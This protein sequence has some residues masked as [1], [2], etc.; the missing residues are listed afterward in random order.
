MS[1]N[2]SSSI[3]IDELEGWQFENLI[4]QLVVEMGFEAE[5]TKR[6]PDGGIDILAYNEQPL[7]Q[8]KYIIQ[9]KR[10]S[11]PINVEII[12]DLYG[13]VHSN[14]ANKG[15]LITNSTFTDTAVE[16]S[17][18]KQ[19]EL[20]DGARLLNLLNQYKIP[21]FSEEQV[22]IPIGVLTSYD[23]LIKP[24]KKTLE[25]IRDIRDGTVYLDK[26]TILDSRYEKFLENHYWKLWEY[27]D[28]L[29]AQYDRSIQLL[30]SNTPQ[31]LE[32][33]KHY[34]K[35]MVNAVEAVTENYIEIVKI[36]PPQKYI[37]LHHG[38]I[39]VFN[40]IFT[41]WEN[42]ISKF[43]DMIKNPPKEDSE[44]DL[45]VDF[46]DIVYS[47]MKFKS[48]YESLI[49][50]SESSQTS[51]YDAL[52]TT[53]DVMDTATSI[54][55]GCFIVTAVYGTPLANELNPFRYYRDDVL[56]ENKIGRSFVKFYYKWSPCLANIIARSNSMKKMLRKTIIEPILRHLISKGFEK[57]S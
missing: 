28:S 39:E 45:I 35:L 56:N 55:S 26:E 4:H 54:A 52:D 10:Y 51:G 53:L 23:H 43:D 15:I 18:D 50:G 30:N 32:E 2:E 5:E 17:R 21:G 37:R 20:I 1:N 25:K 19:I 44:I 49:Y 46:R 8:G 14:N 7:L 40:N 3:N 6:G 9:C 24:M 22:E 41:P 27:N 31:E 42:Y 47:L 11:N 29:I 12:R 38:I 57:K 16:F 33:I 13:V 36:N 34:S 48:L